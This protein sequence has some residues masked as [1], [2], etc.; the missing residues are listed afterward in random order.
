M[1]QF[2]KLILLCLLA[3][4]LLCSCDSATQSTTTK[5]DPFFEQL[6]VRADAEYQALTLKIVTK[7]AGQTLE[8]V[9]DVTEMD[10]N[11]ASITYTIQQFGTFSPTNPLPE[12][13]IETKVGQATLQDGVITSL[14]GEEL[15]LSFSAFTTNRISFKS[16]YFENVEKTAN[17]M[18]AD[19]ANPDGFLSGAGLVGENAKL[20][21]IYGPSILQS[22]VTV[23]FTA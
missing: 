7:K 5:T 16:E 9:F 1:K 6:Q 19:I 13:F 2:S 15:S 4:T 8:S 23:Y 18:T 10:G 12:N 17:G 20:T 3:L 11:S 14:D 22:M 21:V